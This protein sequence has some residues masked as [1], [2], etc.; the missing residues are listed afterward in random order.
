MP[1]LLV[2][3]KRD[4]VR[5]DA[6]IQALEILLGQVRVV[7]DTSVVPHELVPGHL[8]DNTWIVQVCLQ[9]DERERQHERAIGV[10]K[11]IRIVLAILFGELLHHPVDLLRFAGQSE[12]GQKVAQRVGEL[13]PTEVPAIDQSVEDRLVEGLVLAEVVADGRL[14]QAQ[15][16]LLEELGHVHRVVA[17]EAVLLQILDAP[18]RLHVE[19]VDADLQL[20]LALFLRDDVAGDGDSTARPSTRGDASNVITVVAVNTVRVLDGVSSVALV[21]K[22]LLLLRHAASPVHDGAHECDK[23]LQGQGLEFLLLVWLDEVRV[24]K[25]GVLALS[26]LGQAIHHALEDILLV[27][28][29][30]EVKEELECRGSIRAELVEGL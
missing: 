8:L 23:C 21:E 30:I 16:S 19:L 22:A 10:C 28:V 17:D 26:D 20:E 18:L 6:L 14:V 5:D 25:R 27:H 9:H 1:H 7:V 4:R 3:F 12:D 13:L 15:V 11:H 29:A 2:L 24:L